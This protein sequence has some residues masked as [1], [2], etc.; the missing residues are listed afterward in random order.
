MFGADKLDYLQN[1]F[2]SARWKG[3]FKTLTDTTGFNLSIM[4]EQG[5]SIF[6]TE[7]HPSICRALLANDGFRTKCNSYCNSNVSEAISKNSSIIYKCYAGVMSFVLPLEYMQERAVI[8]GQGSFSDYEDFKEFT[9]QLS[10]F[11]NEM[12]IVGPIKFTSSEHATNVCKLVDSSINHLL[13]SS[14]ETIILK[15]KID[16]LKEV[17]G[18]WDTGL[19]DKSETIFK[20]IVTNLFSL[21][22]LEHATIF[23]LDYERGEFISQHTIKKDKKTEIFH[24]KSNDIIVQEFKRGKTHISSTEASIAARIHFLKG[25]KTYYFFPITIGHRLEA[26]LGIFDLHLKESDINIITGFCRQAALRI[27]NHKLRGELN[28]KL[29]KFTSISTAKK[30]IELVLSYEKLLEILLDK[31]AE[32]L[33]AEQGSLMLV[34]RETENLLL[35]SNKG[36]KN[37]IPVQHSIPKGKGIAGRVAQYGEPFLVRDLENDPRIMQKNRDNYKTKSFISVPIK[38]GNRIIGVLNLSDKTTGEVFNEE[39]LEL[40]Q[41]FTSHAAIV[42]ERNVFY[43]QTEELKTLAITDSLTGLLNRRYLDERLEEEL[44]RANRYKRPLSIL[45]LDIDGFKDYNDKLGHYIGDMVLKGISDILCN[46]VRTMDIVAR[47]GGDEFVV[48]L[49]ETDSALALTIGERIRSDVAETKIE[50]ENLSLTVSIGIA[51]F[52]EN[53]NT[54]DQLLK[55]A[56][57]A[58]YRSKGKGGNRVELS[59]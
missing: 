45:L 15:K 10:S 57:K 28:S 12:P 37:G 22:D 2:L 59:S 19:K 38:V 39:D 36:F 53:N 42:I 52:S 54:A 25:I 27:E 23:L 8:L 4:S 7:G 30:D 11:V 14:Q 46:N 48:I 20:H 6:S 16:V 21:L 31:S 47:Y 35:I 29:A 1:L 13:K 32:L 41:S 34:E 43:K 33:K 51:S 24:I 3:R 40:I 9:K 5:T 49:P 56:D 50:P 18:M 26:I 58:L 55:N 17:L 44:S